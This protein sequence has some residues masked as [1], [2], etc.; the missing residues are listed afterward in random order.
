MNRNVG[1]YLGC[2]LN[3]FLHIDLGYLLLRLR[4]IPGVFQSIV[5]GQKGIDNANHW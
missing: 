2:I 5:L 3:A 4:I 1:L